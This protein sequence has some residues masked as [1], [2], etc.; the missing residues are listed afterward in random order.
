MLQL[1]A[2]K[3]NS[4]KLLFRM[5][6]EF[7]AGTAYLYEFNN[8]SFVVQSN[9]DRCLIHQLDNQLTKDLQFG[10]NRV[11]TC[12][13]YEVEDRVDF[14]S[15]HCDC[16]IYFVKACDWIILR[17]GNSFIVLNDDL[18]QLFKEDQLQW[19]HVIN[20]ELYIGTDKKIYKNLKHHCDHEYK[21]YPQEFE[22][23]GETKYY[24]LYRGDWINDPSSNIRRIRELGIPIGYFNYHGFGLFDII[25]GKYVTE[26]IYGTIKGHEFIR[27]KDKWVIQEIDENISRLDKKIQELKALEAKT[28]EAKALEAKTP[29]PRINL[30]NVM[31]KINDHLKT[32]EPDKLKQLLEALDKWEY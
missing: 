22:H 31:E 18:E 14:L 11:R 10:S 13:L 27:R 25:N 6:I 20:D 3:L 16:I 7:S 28:L 17:Y 2:I 19:L 1:V 5:K 30:N 15:E 4:F 12:T 8:K 29:E 24:K 32:M 23:L 26:I 9:C 21:S